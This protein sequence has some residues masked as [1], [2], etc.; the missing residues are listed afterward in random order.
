MT[1]VTILGGAAFALVA[2]TWWCVARHVPPTLAGL[3][4]LP[5]TF[6][7]RLEQSTLTLRGTLPDQSTRDRILRQAHLRFDREQVHVIDELTVDSHVAPAA[8]VEALP[9]LLPFLTHMT[10]RGSVIIDGRSIVLSGRAPNEQAKAT[11]L[12]AM[13]PMTAAGLEL[14][15]HVLAAA[16]LLSPSAQALQAKLDAVLSRSKIEFESNRATLTSQGQSTL[17]RL[18]A[19]L[20]SAPPTTIE[21]GGHTDGYGAADYNLELS[22]RRAEAVKRY[23]VQQG[24]SHRLHAVG[25]GSKRP[26]SH[27]ATPHGLQRNRRIEFHVKG[28]GDL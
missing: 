23:L 26:L 4:S 10:G 13:E 5:A 18:A 9:A 8:W 7:A 1:R 28:N 24:V 6:H 27:D 25:Y 21:I 16:P 3:P 11:L 14:E 12:R 22:R 2:L 20:K 19:V 17:N 15:D